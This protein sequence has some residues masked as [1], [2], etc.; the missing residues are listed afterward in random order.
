MINVIFFKT[1]GGN[2]P[3]RDFLKDL[4]A[5]DRGIIGADL[6]T[7]QIG[8]PIGMPLCRPLGGGLFEVRSDISD[9]RITR[10]VFFQHEQNIIIVEGF[11][12]KTQTTPNDVLDRAKKRKSEYERNDQEI[13]KKLKKQPLKK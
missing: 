9:K 13:K 10:L 7:V 5:A 8:W 12:K 6:R 4:D 2:E 11:I 1:D 3:V